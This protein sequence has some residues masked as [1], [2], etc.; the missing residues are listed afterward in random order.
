MHKNRITLSK[1]LTLNYINSIIQS[2]R[3]TVLTGNGEKGTNM[4]RNM[5]KLIDEYKR[6]IERRKP[7]DFNGSEVGELIDMAGNKDRVD[8]AL[9]LSYNAVRAGYMAGWKAA[10]RDRAVSNKEKAVRYDYYMAGVINAFVAVASIYGEI[11]DDLYE[12]MEQMSLDDDDIRR[13]KEEANI[14]DDFE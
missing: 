10:K 7:L 2:E 1:R 8:Y 13:V 4:N 5:K 9:D 6:L 11:T 3:E 14:E 12:A